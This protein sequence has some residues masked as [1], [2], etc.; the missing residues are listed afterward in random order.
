MS[1]GW[2][3]VSS[4]SRIKLEITQ[5]DLLPLSLPS[6]LFSSH[7]M[8]AVIKVFDCKCVNG[9]DLYILICPNIH[10]KV[11][12]RG[13]LCSGGVWCGRTAGDIKSTKLKIINSY[14]TTIAKRSNVKTCL[15]TGE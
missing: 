12:E 6:L 15:L 9:G 3:L 8:H 4:P 10:A 2:C 5:L 1:V 13:R 7:L 11:V 14:S